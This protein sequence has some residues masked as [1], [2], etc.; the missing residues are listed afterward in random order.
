MIFILFILFLLS[1][2]T[3]FQCIKLFV[4]LFIDDKLIGALRCSIL[5]EDIIDFI[6]LYCFKGIASSIKGEFY[7]TMKYYVVKYFVGIY[8]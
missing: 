6:H 4:I 2:L 1:K 3:A 7:D 5:M 8:I